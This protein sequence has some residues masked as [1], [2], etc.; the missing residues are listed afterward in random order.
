MNIRTVTGTIAPGDVALADAHAHAWIDPPEAVAPEARLELNDFDRIRSE[1]SRFRQV[2]GSLLVDCQPGGAGRDANQLAALSQATGVRI[3]ATTGFHLRRYYPAGAWLWSC[4]TDEAADLF[5]EELTAGMRE[6]GG[7]VPATTIKVG[8]DGSLDG[9]AR[10]LLEAAAIAAQQTGALVLFHTEQGRNAE[11]L[12]PFFAAR[13]VPPQRLYL[14]HMDKR[15]DAALHCELAR[16]GALLGYDTFARPQY[17]PDRHVWPLIETLVAD[18]LH[19]HI[20]LGLDLAHAAT[21]GAYGGKPGLTFLPES[22]VPRLR[23]M[24]LDEAIVRHLVAQNIARYLV[25]PRKE[26]G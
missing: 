21:W 10:P 16:A 23:A 2:G 8:F 19:A 17:D 18:G 20:A 22:V 3:T 5:L 1:L 9:Q 25:P 11:A 4:A 6:T 15:P 26:R 12:L 7:T 24:G 14:C 13:G